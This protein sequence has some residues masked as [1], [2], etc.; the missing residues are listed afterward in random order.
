M[1][2]H[3]PVVRKSGSTLVIQER[4]GFKRERLVF[5]DV[6][7]TH[8]IAK[9][10]PQ[11]FEYKAGSSLRY[12]SGE[13]REEEKM[14]HF[15]SRF[16][17]HWELYTVIYVVFLLIAVWATWYAYVGHGPRIRLVNHSGEDLFDIWVDSGMQDSKEVYEDQEWLSR[18]AKWVERLKD[19]H[20]K[21]V[22]LRGYC[23]N[24]I[25]IAFA[26]SERKYE[27]RHTGIWYESYSRKVRETLTVLAG[28]ELR[29]T[30]N[31]PLQK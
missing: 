28:G 20:T 12:R 15:Y 25:Y 31:E 23:G 11:V 29:L 10:T 22:Q 27:R 7:A 3:R 17:A 6:N 5:M 18:C 30:S 14:T 26:T 1:C 21:R 13:G 4:N 24:G 9:A 2:Y 19:S 16:R 8:V